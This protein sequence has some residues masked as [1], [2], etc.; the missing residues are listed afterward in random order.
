MADL[1][2]TLGL[3]RG[4]TEAE[5]KAAYRKLAKQLHPDKTKDNPKAAERFKEVSAAY[6]ILG[7]DEK[8][9]QYDRGEIDDQGNP[10]APFGFGGGGPGAGAGAGANP[11]GFGGGPGGFTQSFEFGGGDPG[12]LF[13]ELFG[14]A[15]GSSAG[16]ANGFGFRPNA[17]PKGADRQ[18]RLAI[19]FE[20]AARL[21]PQ[22]VALVGGQTVD[23]KLPAGF[24]D[25]TK[26]RLAGKGDAGPG[27]A[28][29]AIVELAIEP[30]AFFT[31]DGDDVRL[32]LPVRLDEAV[33]GAKV[34][35]PTV[36]GP[37]TVTV[38][39]GSSSGRVL[40]LRGKGFHR[41]GGER[42]D[43][44]VTLAVDLPVDDPEL[45]RFAEGWTGDQGRNPRA[46][47]GV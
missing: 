12:D 45:R 4:A 10:R 27:G 44:L 7:E 17:R 2:D 28:G 11:F 31:R 5:I 22:R 1:Y 16:G 8:R 19:E 40:R 9:A 37:V 42:G 14:R 39:P 15:T 25:G 32:M 24:T 41:K 18:Y 46:R 21:D 30:H 34:R 13:A 26:V 23:L 36:D 33:L 43:Q 35:T 29:D 47:L 20:E 6:A 38:P 3:K